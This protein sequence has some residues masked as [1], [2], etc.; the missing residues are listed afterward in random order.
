M[1][2]VTSSLGLGFLQGQVDHFRDRGYNVT[3]ISSPGDECASA[4]ASGLPT[5]P[6]PM[7]REI[8]PFR[9]LLALWRLWRIMRRLRP[10]I[11]NVSTP[12]A[13]FLGGLA[14][15][16]AGVPC[17]VY[18]L[19]GLRCETLTGVSR[20]F[21]LLAERI[22][23]LSAHRVLCVSRSLRRQAVA[24]GVVDREKSRVLASGS[25]NG[26]EPSQFDWDE[27]K[28]S[29][30]IE[31]RGKLGI[32]RDAPV[33]GFAGRFTRDKGIAE[34]LEAASFLRI[35]FP[36]LRLLLVG[37]GDE[38]DQ[39]PPGIRSRI[40]VDPNIICSGFVTDPAPYYHLMDVLALPTH[41]EG[42]PN[43]VLEANAAGKPAVVTDATGAVD[44]VIDGVTGFIVR[45]GDSAAL[46]EALAKLFNDR[47]LLAAMGTN[48]RK[49][50]LAEFQ[51][52]HIW[53]DL[54][55][56]YQS[57]LEA[58]GLRVPAASVLVLDRGQVGR[59]EPVP[60]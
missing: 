51:P 36:D 13:G 52:K 24:L 40:L 19:R 16:F 28:A 8:S 9:D 42:F 39:L 41:R 60:L 46:A 6:V 1:Y 34:L 29:Q 25:S 23:C 58:R 53:E 12:K 4:A 5:I 59:S 45:V 44:S 10:A 47:M 18:T 38:G 14:A 7:A 17:R 56:E 20:C 30:I 32:P 35:R 21:V 48:A 22:A 50:V 33:V 49:R 55:R 54:R 57:L 11:T 15:Y 27:A 31:L 2:V 26:V 43:V 3:V 37:D